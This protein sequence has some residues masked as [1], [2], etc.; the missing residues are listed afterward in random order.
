MADSVL[1]LA[2]LLLRRAE[3]AC[4]DG[5]EGAGERGW[6]CASGLPSFVGGG[7]RVRELWGRGG[8]GKMQLHFHHS[9]PILRF[10]PPFRALVAAISLPLGLPAQLAPAR[11]P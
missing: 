5:G 3:A 4:G 2:L 6:V 11:T 7:W 8:G 9:R 10:V 1:V